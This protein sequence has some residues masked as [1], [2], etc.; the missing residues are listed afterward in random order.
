MKNRLSLIFTAIGIAAICLAG[1]PCPNPF[2]YRINHEECVLVHGGG[3]T[4]TYRSAVPGGCQVPGTSSKK[5]Q[6]YGII[7]SARTKKLTG[8]YEQNIHGHW[9]YSICEDDEPYA[10][11]GLATGRSTQENCDYCTGT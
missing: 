10:Y 7:D 5:C 9:V 4:K 6:V 11:I 8:F 2:S 1:T 3:W